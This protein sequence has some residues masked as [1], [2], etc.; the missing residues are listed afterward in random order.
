M[1]APLIPLPHCQLFKEHANEYSAP[2]TLYCVGPHYAG[3]IRR[4]T[5]ATTLGGVVQYFR[6]MDRT[7]AEE[8]M[9][10]FAR[11][12]RAGRTNDAGQPVRN[13]N[14]RVMAA[15]VGLLHVAA[16]HPECFAHHPQVAN[17]LTRQDFQHL[18]AQWGTVCQVQRKPRPRAEGHAMRAKHG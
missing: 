8:A 17:R 3:Q 5:G 1:S 15:L 14:P 7:T 2:E 13:V 4:I 12:A 10:L 18:E 11:N 16:T 9:H 6:G